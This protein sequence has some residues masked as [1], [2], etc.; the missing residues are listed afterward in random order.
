MHPSSFYDLRAH[1]IYTPLHGPYSLSEALEGLIFYP[2]NE[3]RDFIFIGSKRSLRHELVSELSNVVDDLHD[4]LLY[5]SSTFLISPPTSLDLIKELR[6]S[7]LGFKYISICWGAIITRLTI[8]RG[9][10]EH[11]FWPHF[12]HQTIN[13]PSV[14]Q[15]FGRPPSSI[16]LDKSFASVSAFAFTSPSHMDSTPHSQCYPLERQPQPLNAQN[17]YPERLR[18][19]PSDV[20]PTGGKQDRTLSSTLKIPPTH[21]GSHVTQVPSKCQLP[22]ISLG[23]H[24]PWI[25]EDRLEEVLALPK[26][27]D[28]AHSSCSSTSV[29]AG[30]TKGLG[31]LED[32]TKVVRTDGQVSE[33]LEGVTDGEEAIRM[34]YAHPHPVQLTTTHRKLVMTPARTASSSMVSRPTSTAPHVPNSTVNPHWGPSISPQRPYPSPRSFT[35]AIPQPPSAPLSL[36]SMSR[37]PSST[38]SQPTSTSWQ[39]SSMASRPTSIIRGPAKTTPPSTASRFQS[40]TRASA[41]VLSPSTASQS[42]LTAPCISIF[43]PTHHQEHSILLPH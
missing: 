39:P 8:A 32:N 12:F 25:F 33:G 17:D 20:N 23:S 7:Y 43:T 21:S 36:S 9:I 40:T 10:V 42:T 2:L 15:G 24:V 13:N 27:T 30:D 38:V 22:D 3:S 16:M 31:R 29:R 6:T 19:M 14:F 4:Y 35:Q 34:S 1:Y 26:H 5:F 11:N 37:S 28:A 41:K 18:T